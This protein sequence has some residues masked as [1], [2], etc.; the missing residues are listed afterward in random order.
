MRICLLSRNDHVGDPRAR[1]L[2]ASLARAGHE[3]RVVAVGHRPVAAPALS[4]FVPARR[5]VGGGAIG[6]LLRLVQPPILRRW[7]LE[8]SLV[9]AVR[10][11]EPDIV[12]PA[13][14]ALVALACRAAGTASMVMR[15]PA[16]PDAGSR[17]LVATAPSRPLPPPSPEGPAVFH[18]PGDDRDGWKPVPDRWQG[19]RIALAYRRTLSNPGRYLEAALVRAGV[20]VSLHVDR[21]DLDALPDGTAAVVFV[22]SP[23]PPLEV[24]GEPSC[25][26]LFW[27]HHGEHHLA[28][29]L[30]LAHRYRAEAVLLAHSWHLAHRFHVPTYRFPFAID[31]D[32]FDASM[33]WDQRRVTVSMVGSHLRGGGPYRRRQELVELLESGLA[34]DATGFREGV[35]PA[36]MAALYG[37]SRIVVNEGGVRHFPIT[38]RVF[39]AVAA[40]A[41]LLT[42]PI[43]GLDQLFSPQHHYV[44]LD[45]DPLAQ[46][47]ALAQDPHAALIAEAALVHARQRHTYDHRVDEVLQIARASRG[48]SSDAEDRLTASRLATVIERDVEVQRILAV[49]APALPAALPDREV[50]EFERLQREPAP[51]SY[52]AVV[53]G[54]GTDPDSHERLLKAARRYLYVA[55]SAAAVDRFLSGHHPTAQLSRFAEVLRVDLNAPGYRISSDRGLT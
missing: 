52:E 40:G 47:S 21:V 18:T 28:A 31:T 46:V 51:G 20:D 35:P 55:G 1:A 13:S 8:R 48:G 37:R 16:W 26:V 50:W 38:M 15:D 43:P 49:G 7:L 32:L 3:V 2:R 4:S 6:R 42:D 27:V 22:E 34:P 12:Y 36:E 29:N 9:Q 25:P 17:D 53:L 23:Y 39:E 44:T 54:P 45:A 33:P 24:S 41:L 14:A 19:T 5:P 10:A 11:A 30:R